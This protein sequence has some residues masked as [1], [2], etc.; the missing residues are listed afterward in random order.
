MEILVVEFDQRKYKEFISSKL[1]SSKATPH[2]H[3]VNTKV[4]TS[5]EGGALFMGSPPTLQRRHYQSK[6]SHS[7]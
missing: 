5:I 7:P 4:M 1:T 6:K 2:Y 3:C